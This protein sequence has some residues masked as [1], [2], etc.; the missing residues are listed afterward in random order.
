MIAN[1]AVT[2]GLI[3]LAVLGT[4]QT[5]VADGGQVRN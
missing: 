1:V 3:Y 2:G 4:G 5:I